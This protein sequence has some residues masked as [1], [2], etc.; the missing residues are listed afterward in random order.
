MADG[1]IYTLNHNLDTISQ[2][3]SDES[4][5]SSGQLAPKVG[6]TFRI[7]EEAEVRKA[8]MISNIDDIL[9][10]VKEMGP[11]ELDAKGIPI[12]RL[13]SLI[14]KEDNLTDLLYQFIGAGYAP[15]I[16]FESGRITALKLEIN[17]ICFLIQRNK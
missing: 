5:G 9:N 10:V 7:N 12:T 1:H 11:A 2:H 13:M 16:N 6:D 14:H 4:D 15:G 17:K 8:K 3:Q